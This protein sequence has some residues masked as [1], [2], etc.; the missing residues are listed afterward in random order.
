MQ[1]PEGC[2]LFQFGFHVESTDAD[3][4]LYYDDIALSANQFLQTSSQG[5]S[6][7]YWTG[8]QGSLWSATGGATGDWNTALL[9]SGPDTPA[10]GDSKLVRFSDATNQSVTV[11]RIYAKE[12]INLELGVMGAVDSGDTLAI[13][14]SSD[15]VLIREHQDPEAGADGLSIDVNLSLTLAKEDYVYVYCANMQDANGQ[16]NIRATP[17]VNDVV[18]LNSQDEI[19]T[20]WVDFDPVWSQDGGSAGPVAPTSYVHRQLR[21]RRVGSNMEIDGYFNYDN[22]GTNGSSTYTLALPSG[23]TI[24]PGELYLNLSK[25]S[26][27]FVGEGLFNNSTTMNIPCQVRAYSESYL[28]FTYG[29]SNVYV[30]GGVGFAAG[31]WRLSFRASVPI[32]GWTSTFNPV[33]SMPLV[34]IGADTE[35]YHLNYFTAAAEHSLYSA[36]TP[37]TNTISSLGTVNNTSA[38]DGGF[39][40]KASTRVKVDFNY[41]ARLSTGSGYN[42]L[43]KCTEAYWNTGYSFDESYWDNLRLAVVEEETGY[44]RGVSTSTILEPGE[45][46]GIIRDDTDAPLVSGTPNWASGVSIVV[47]RDR[48]HTNLAHIIKP[49]VCILEHVL[50]QGTNAGGSTQDSWQP[51]ELNTI[52]GESWFLN[53]LSSNIFSL[54]KGQYKFKAQSIF[55]DTNDIRLRLYDT[56]NSKAVLYSMNNYQDPSEIAFGNVLLDGL[57]TLTTDT[58]FRLEYYCKNAKSVNGLGSSQNLTG[59]EEIYTRVVI[60]KLK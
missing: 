3:V 44:V 10:Y 45:V 23:Y 1:F 39:Y 49:A 2:R 42:A 51:R 32:A 14:D 36:S 15:N 7:Y 16:M 18:L 8:Y 41:W 5:Q 33:L 60:E 30:D 53:S 40:F 9:E 38:A 11:T 48:S 34:D 56:S 26:S 12:K 19:F 24:A 43:V 25:N 22:A 58:S 46:I 28:F 59:V 4:E 35:Y 52:K 21:W 37:I 57:F 50:S 31:N 54:P 20:D 17:Q 55:Y 13:C 6:E 47:E 27:Q 29:S